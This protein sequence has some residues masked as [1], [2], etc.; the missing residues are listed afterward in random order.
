MIGL[1]TTGCEDLLKKKEEA[2]VVAS[3]PVIENTIV[4]DSIEKLRVNMEKG[5]LDS[6]KEGEKWVVS[7]SPELT[8]Y[9]SYKIVENKMIIIVEKETEGVVIISQRSTVEVA[10]DGKIT[11]TTE[12]VDSTGV[13]KVKNIKVYNNVD[14]LLKAEIN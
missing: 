4:K 3:T 5:L 2:G 1:T 11:H 12:E 13:L 9:L 8:I 10:K 7:E 14:E 6:K